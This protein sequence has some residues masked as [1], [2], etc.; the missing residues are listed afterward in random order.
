MIYSQRASARSSG[1]GARGER[2][3]RGLRD[4]E[5]PGLSEDPAEIVGVLNEV[6]LVAG[7]GLPAAAGRVHSRLAKAAV[8]ERGKDLARGWVDVLG[9]TSS[10]D[11]SLAE[12]THAPR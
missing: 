10:G 6:D 3:R 5:V 2:A 7:A 8:N 9:G 1:A 11:A 12:R 4:G